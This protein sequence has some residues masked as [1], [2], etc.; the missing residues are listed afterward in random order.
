MSRQPFRH[1][2]SRCAIAITLGLTVIVTQSAVA[3]S[4]YLERIASGLAQPTFLA[5]APGDP[6]NIIY[7]STRISAANGTGGGFSTLNDMGGIFRYDMNTR[8]SQLVMSLEHRQLLGDEGLAGFAFSPDFNTPGAPGYQK[9]YVSSSSFNDGASPIDRVEEYVVDSN[10]TVPTDGLGRPVVNRLILEY[11]HVNTQQNHTVDWIGFDPRAS[12]LPVGSAERNYLYIVTGDGDLGGNAQSRPEQKANSVPGKLLRVDVDP[13]NGDAYPGDPNKNFAIPASNP[14]PLWNSTHTANE[15][16]V[17]TTL[18]YTTNP[19]TATYAPALEEIYATGLRNAFR[20]SFDRQTGDFWAGDV[21]EFTREEINFLRADIYEDNEGNLPPLDYGYAQ[22][23][24][25]VG[26]S[27]NLGV[28]GSSGDTTLQWDLS[29][30]DTKIVDSVN[31]IREGMHA[32]TNTPDEVRT[33]ER[34]AYIG[35]YVY[36][37]PVESLQGNYFYSDYIYGN[38]FMLSDFDRNMSLEDYSGTNFNQVD[39]VAALGTRTT[40]ATAD[41]D[42]LWQSLI[43]DFTDPNYTAALGP[44]F[45][46]GRA[47]SFGEDN[48]GN[49]YIIDFGGNRGDAS[50]GG[51]YPNAGLGEIFRIVPSLQIKVVVD[52]DTGQITLE[53]QEGD[54]VDLRAYSLNSSHGS[55][56]PSQIISITDN[57]DANPPG[58]GS[59]DGNDHWEITSPVDSRSQFSE[60]TTGD[61]GTLPVSGS[62]PYSADGGWTKSIYE[63][64]Q[65]LITLGNGSTTLGVVEYVGNSG[66]PFQ[67]SDLNFNGELDPGDWPLFR[68]NHLADLSGLTAAQ[69][70]R[71]GDL[72]GDGDNDFADFRLFQADYIAANGQAAFAALLNVPEPG[73]AVLVVVLCAAGAL[74]CRRDIRGRSSRPGD[75]GAAAQWPALIVAALILWGTLAPACRAALQHR[76]S[77]NEGATGNATGRTIID[78]IGGAHGTVLGDDSSASATQLILPGGSSATQAYVDLPNGIISSLTDATFE[79]WYTIDSTFNRSWGRVF[80]FGSTEGGEL[81]GPGGG[82]EGLDYIFYSPMRGSDIDQQRA[83]IRNNDE[84]FGPGGTAGN[85]GAISTMDPEFDHSLDDQYHMALVFDADGGND[86]GEATMTL[87]INGAIPPGEN[88]NPIETI[89]QLNNLNDVNNWLGRSNWTGDSNFDGSFNEFRIYDQTLD[90]DQIAANFAAGPD[91]I[92]KLAEISLEVNTITGSVRINNSVVDPTKI[93]YYRITSAGGALDTDKWNSLDDQNADAVGGDEGESWDEADGSNSSSLTELFLLGASGVSSTDPLQ[94]GH[95]FDVSIFGPGADGDL[96]F[97][98]AKQGSSQLID[99]SVMYVTPGPLS[100]DYNHNG[101]VDAADFVVW[102]ETFGSTTVLDADG[103]GDGKVDQFDYVVWRYTFGNSADSG[104]AAI[105]NTA[106]ESASVLLL[107]SGALCSAGLY[108]RRGICS[109]CPLR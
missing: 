25:T 10:G 64:L 100:G 12:S 8:T 68:M 75:R 39:G 55:I 1:F 65:F 63:D 32:V 19:T 103:D 88:N 16:L 99:A 96:Q 73:T 2:A 71:L 97:Q 95:A 26:T 98:Y 42:S 90:A 7:Y 9:L 4:Y 82:G 106:P 94:L 43:V 41:A 85:V 46:I 101:T 36:R 80:D 28:S 59:I 93:D 91:V 60:Q 81:T 108:R 13:A 89:V 102:R 77:F 51:D 47:V 50:F 105:I 78:S 62:F 84:L 104:S 109:P 22:R 14:I 15:Q 66:Q 45:G 92:P 18:N 76:Y 52:R 57:Y 30:G 3:Q 72:D 74:I 56:D 58:D 17:S 21:G 53:N 87:Y 11:L 54:P 69:S 48:D 83:E 70:Y 44:S 37:G 24:G 5:Q 40:V 86:P 6:A 38:I 34:S 31:P 79:A 61:A 49:L 23:E 29:G 33:D 27:L 35:G 107:I 20:A 67:R